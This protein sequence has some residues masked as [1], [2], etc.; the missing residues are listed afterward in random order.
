MQNN[1]KHVFVG[2][3]GGIDSSATVLLLKEQGYRVTGVTFVGLGGDQKEFQSGKGAFIGKSSRK[4]CSTEE[5]LVAKEVCYNLGIKHITLDLS[6]IFKQKVR[7]PF[8]KSYL[9]G[10]T[11]N[12]CMLCNR[13]VKLGA[14]VDFAK[15]N[16]ADFVAMGHYTGVEEVNGE[17]LLKAGKDEQKDQS[18]FLALLRPEI[19]SYLLFPLADKEKSEIRSIVAQ[20]TLPINSNKSESQDVCFVD[21]DFRNYLKKDGIAEHKGNIIFDNKVIGEHTGIAFYALGQRKG[22][23]VSLGQKVF[24]REINANNNTL[25][26]GEKPKSIRFQVSELNIFSEKFKD[27]DWDIQIR[28]R[29]KRISGKVQFLEQDLLEIELSSPQEI[30]TP[31]QFAVFYKN[32][33]IYAA[34]KIIN[35]VLL[36]NNTVY[37]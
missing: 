22:L 1:P 5:V 30:V 36:N 31:G 21:D 25:I 33:Y 10:E 20:S 35:I 24:V 27:G 11:P 15:E 3:S 4:C 16:G 28:Y 26:L 32:N 13:Y 19:L 7:D 34:G 17:F 9:T 14:L 2:M 37:H 23:G 29:S 12:P 6:K 8:T 18:Y